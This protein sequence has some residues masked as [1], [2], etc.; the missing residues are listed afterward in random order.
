[1]EDILREKRCEMGREKVVNEGEGYERLSYEDTQVISTIPP[2]Q[3][4]SSS[5]S[6]TLFDP[7]FSLNP[8]HLFSFITAL[9]KFFSMSVEYKTTLFF[10]PLDS[11]EFIYDFLG[12]QLLLFFS[13]GLVSAH[14]CVLKYFLF[15]V[16]WINFFVPA[17]FLFEVCL[18]SFCIQLTF[19]KFHL[20]S[21]AA[22]CL[23][24]PFFYSD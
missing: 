11:P 23:C 1:M 14:F 9:H 19:C 5:L 12:S 3:L 8:P 21:F 15:Y 16:Y 17:R 22:L 6:S 4:P 18:F 2:P 20:C 13:H 7:L 10:T 24:F